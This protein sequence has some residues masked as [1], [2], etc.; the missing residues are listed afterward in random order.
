MQKVIGIV[1][2]VKQDELS[3]T[4]D[5][6]RLRVHARARVERPR[7]RAADVGAAGVARAAGGR[8]RSARIDPEQPVEDIRTMDD[9]LDETLTSQRFSALL[10]GAV[11]GRRAR[12]GDGRASTACSRTSS[13]AAAARSA[14]GPRSAR[15]P[16][17]SCAWSCVEGMTPALIGIAAGAVAALGSGELLEKLVFGVSASDP[18]TLAA[19]AGD[20]GAGGAAGEPGAGVPGRRLDPLTVLRG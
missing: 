6:D 8:R 7:A 1:G 15:G 5:A 17:T 4:A 2:D 14:S 16:A 11:R 10:L 3:E 20:A 12:A 13:A 19:V 18:L 9:V